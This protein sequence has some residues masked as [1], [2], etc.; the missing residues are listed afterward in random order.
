MPRFPNISRYADGVSHR[1]YSSLATRAQEKNDVVFP[2]H[3]GDTYR[4]PIES[5]RAEHQR[6]AEH[7]GLHKY[8]PVQGEPALL[9]AILTFVARRHGVSLERESVQVMAGATAG[10]NIVTQVLLE[11][12]DEVLMPSPFWPLSRGIVATKGAR[13]VQIPFYTKLDDPGFDAESVLESKITDRTVAIYLNT[14]NNPTGR[15]VPEPVLDAMLRVAARHDLWVLC[16]EAYEEIYFDDAPPITAWKHPAIRER[17]I[18]FHTLSKTYGFAGARVGFTHGP[19]SVMTAVRGMQTFQTYCAPRP[20][21]FGAIHAL[22]E[23]QAWVEESRRAYHAAAKKAAAAL[24]MPVPQGGTF[25]FKDVSALVASADDCVP[26]LE[27]CA[28]VGVLLTPGRACGQDYAKWIRLCFTAVPPAQLDLAL[29]RVAP[30]FEE[31]ASR[32]NRR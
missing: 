21:Q 12:G 5:A 2:L 28:D 1:V 10:L 3:V 4:D 15:I 20:M 27:A 6:S 18:A 11:P 13:A 31:S 22:A 8:A 14:P 30:L 9:D 29:A 25:L 24:H 16:D 7:S 19:A 26:L 23:G 17:A 32:T